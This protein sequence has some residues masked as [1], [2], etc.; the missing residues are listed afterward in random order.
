MNLGIALPQW[1]FSKDKKAAPLMLLG[2]VGGGILLPLGLMSW[3]MLSSSKFTGP[4]Q[5]LNETYG[6]FMYSK[7]AIKESQVRPHGEHTA[8]TA[9]TAHCTRPGAPGC[10]HPPLPQPL[11]CGGDPCA[12]RQRRGGMLYV[13]RHHP[14]RARVSSSSHNCMHAAAALRLAQQS[15]PARTPAWPAR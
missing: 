8:H 12:R 14:V 5:I 1:M 6:I 10:G 3:Y 13:A 15:P 4:N 9:H 11:R 7:Y 2:L